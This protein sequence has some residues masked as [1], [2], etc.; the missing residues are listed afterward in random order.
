MQQRIITGV[1]A[2]AVF[3]TI[4]YVGQLA[5]AL[6]ITALA[7]IAIHEFT[8]MHA[9]KSLHAATIFAFIVT[10]YF[11][12]P[13]HTYFR[14]PTLSFEVLIWFSL[15]IFM[16]LTVLSKNKINVKHIAI[17]FVGVVYISFGFYYMNET[18]LMDDGLFWC[19]L[20]FASI[21][22]TDIGAYFTGWAIGKRLL[23][24]AISPK[25]TMEGALGGILFSTGTALLFAWYAPDLI[26][27]YEAIVFGV[28]V[29]I[30]AQLGDFIQSAYKRTA[31]VKDAGAIFPGHGGVLDRC[32]SWIIV[33]PFV[34]LLSVLPIS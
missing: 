22:L 20:I 9:L 33:F 18:R 31:G 17:V 16:L 25:K 4:L 10:L 23:W 2:A 28:V 1:V 3:L 27:F 24:P 21:W 29:S 12:F 13:W 15:F 14:L 11:V 34:H 32:D 26:S 6:M 19:L 8:K 7:L 5:Y 30:V